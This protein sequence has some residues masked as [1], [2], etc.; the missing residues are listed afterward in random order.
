VLRVA[1][2]FEEGTAPP[3]SRPALGDAPLFKLLDEA[4]FFRAYLPH[5]GTDALN[6]DLAKHPATKLALA[7]MGALAAYWA[8]DSFL[9]REAWAEWSGKYLTP[10][11]VVGVIAAILGGLAL[12]T[13]KKPEPVP[14]HIVLPVALLLGLAAALASWTGLIRLNQAFGGP[15]VE[16]AYVR[17]DT[18]DT[19]MPLERGLPDIEYTEQA[20][21]YW[22]QFSGTHRH[23]VPVRRGLGGLYQ[24]DLSR[25]TAAIREYRARQAR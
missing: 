8:A 21:H 15:L 9:A 13:A 24:V 25:H 3:A 11:A 6:F 16:R 10:H 14:I 7:V 20:R 23:Y 12:E 5:A 17:N 19:L 22:C 1:D 2:W 4:G 18:C